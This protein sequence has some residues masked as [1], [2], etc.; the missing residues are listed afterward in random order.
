MKPA[1]LKTTFGMPCKRLGGHQS[2]VWNGDKITVLL[3]IGSHY[4]CHVVY[5]NSQMVVWLHKRA[6]R[7]G[8]K[9]KR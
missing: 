3:R 1:R 8:L 6:V 5:E 4:L 2:A 9:E 7:V